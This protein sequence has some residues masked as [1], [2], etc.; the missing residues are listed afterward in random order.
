[1]LAERGL[2]VDIL[3]EGKDIEAVQQV[4]RLAREI[5]NLRIIF[6]HLLGFKVDGTAAT[7]RAPSGAEII[8]VSSTSSANTL[9]R[10]GKRPASAIFG[11]T[12]A[13]PTGSAWSKLSD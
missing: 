11:R 6:S 5:P 7:G 3:G 10:R 2:S 13:K 4:D 8:R 12:L 9:P 1:M